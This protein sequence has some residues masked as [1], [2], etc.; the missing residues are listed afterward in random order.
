M[1]KFN[2]SDTFA[3][4]YY[5]F[6]PCDPCAAQFQSLTSA[7]LV[8]VCCCK[9]RVSCPCSPGSCWH[10]TCRG[11]EVSHSL[12]CLHCSTATER[13]ISLFQELSFT[14]CCKEHF[15]LF[16]L[17]A[18]SYLCDGE[19]L[20]LGVLTKADHKQHLRGEEQTAS[21]LLTRPTHNGHLQGHVELRAPQRLEHLPVVREQSK[22]G[23]MDV[24]NNLWQYSMLHYLFRGT[25]LENSKFT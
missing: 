15:S 14:L 22:Q 20:L 17:T 24:R 10:S 1:H 21:M 7:S 25:C 23:G 16:S 2:S 13:F 8:T 18:G 3:H 6:A 4:Q 5:C 9:V 12:H 11:H 19:G